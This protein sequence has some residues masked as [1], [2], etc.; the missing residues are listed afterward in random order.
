MRLASARWAVA[1]AVAVPVAMALLAG[2]AAQGAKVLS[3]GD[4]DTLRVLDHGRPIIIRLACIDAPEMAQA[5]YGLQARRQL[6]QQV[7]VGHTVTVQ[8]HST[9]RYG[10]QV[11]ELLIGSGPLQRNLNLALVEAGQA[12]AYRKYLKQCD[13]AAYL[14]AEAQATRRREGVWS[15]SGGITRP[16]EFRRNRRAH[17]NRSGS[18]G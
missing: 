14:K 18:G 9:D 4:G 8:A 15:V 2:C 6:Q 17:R 1:V 11:A 16:W 7:A 13:A 5:P 3:I 10:R 12:F